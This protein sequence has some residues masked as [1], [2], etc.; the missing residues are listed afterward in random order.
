MARRQ[1]MSR[2]ASEPDQLA[3]FA[4]ASVDSVTYASQRREH[5]RYAVELD[6][7]L[8]SDHNFYAGFAENLSAGGVFIATH[9]LKPAGELIEF[10]VNLPNLGGAV[11]GLGEVRWTREY[12]ERS[13]V[14]PGLGLRFVKLEP[15][16]KELIARFLVHRDPIFFDDE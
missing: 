11:R 2:V 12:C 10:S 6:V 15:G 16:S 9:V 1:P 7:S 14:P 5:P 13:N 4:D 8:G 3:R